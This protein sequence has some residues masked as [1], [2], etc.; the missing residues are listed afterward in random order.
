M[1]MTMTATLADADG[2]PEVSLRHDNVPPGVRP[3]DNELGTRQSLQKLAARVEQQ[4]R[5]VE[6]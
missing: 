4:G 3:K 5:Y 1:Q 2:G 6:S